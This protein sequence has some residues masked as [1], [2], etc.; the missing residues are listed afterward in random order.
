MQNYI[1]DVEHEIRESVLV[2]EQ[3]MRLAPIIAETTQAVVDCYK[4][5]GKLVMFGNGGSAADAQHIVAELVNKLHFDRP[6]LNALALTVNTSVLTAIGNDSSYDNI[7]SRQ[8]E[9]LVD[10]KDIVIGLSTSGNSV[11]VI[12]GLE[13]AKKLGCV[14]IAMTGHSGGKMK[15]IPEILINIPSNKNTRIQEAHITIGHII[16]AL[17]EREMFG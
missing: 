16:C 10:E 15:N 4:K 9:S 3:T 5:G 8:I 12:K 13:A 17:V 7:F 11:N 6:M 2:K 14:T 1:D